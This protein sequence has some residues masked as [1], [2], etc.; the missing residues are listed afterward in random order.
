MNR[1]NETMPSEKIKDIVAGFCALAAGTVSGGDVQ[2]GKDLVSEYI[3]P[4]LKEFG[5]EH[6]LATIAGLRVLCREV[7]AQVVKML[8][9]TTEHSENDE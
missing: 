6:Q 7:A 8:D 4:T 1:M 3:H 5:H 2:T 9:G